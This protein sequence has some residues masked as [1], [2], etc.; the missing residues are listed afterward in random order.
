MDIHTRMQ[1][2]FKQQGAHIDRIYYCPHY[3]PSSHAE[4]GQEC[5]CRKPRPGMGRQAVQD[6]GIDPARSYMIGD[7]V[8]DIQFGLNLG[9][10]PILVLTGYGE[11]SQSKLKKLG[12]EPAFVAPNLGDAVNWIMSEEENSFKK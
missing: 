11:K 2:A 9:A 8:E 6:L 7:K 10:I 4:Y 5:D 1:A 3:L 12:I